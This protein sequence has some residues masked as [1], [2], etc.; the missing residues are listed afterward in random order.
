ML[1]WCA[2]RLVLLLSYAIC[3]HWWAMLG[4]CSD[5]LWGILCLSGFICQAFQLDILNFQNGFNKPSGQNPPGRIHMFARHR[6][7][8]RRQHVW[9]PLLQGGA[10]DPQQISALNGLTLL[11]LKTPTVAHAVTDQ[12]T[13]S[14][15]TLWTFQWPTV[16][17]IC[18][19]SVHHIS[20]RCIWSIQVHLILFYFW[21]NYTIIYANAEYWLPLICQAMD[22][23][24]QG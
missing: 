17:Q 15:K 2:L 19:S 1:S 13:D 4:Q 16:L 11:E 18:P 10:G 3:S 22:G 5:C 7:L 12:C 20:Y 14:D 23:V 6:D 21:S 9:L 24:R 8:S